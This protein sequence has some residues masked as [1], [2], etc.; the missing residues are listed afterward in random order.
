[1]ENRFEEG[2]KALTEETKT[3]ALSEVLAV[4]EVSEETFRSGWKS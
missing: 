2:G 1:M 4:K 3:K